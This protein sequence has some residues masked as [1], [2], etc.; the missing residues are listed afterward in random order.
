MS[1][2]I[3]A[4]TAQTTVSGEI[5]A[6]GVTSQVNTPKLNPIGLLPQHIHGI[7]P[8]R[9]HTQSAG[10]VRSPER[11]GGENVHTT[12]IPHENNL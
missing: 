1:F 11:V 2:D 10:A 7:R 12:G 8:G 3:W 4:P 9:I 5:T 6:S